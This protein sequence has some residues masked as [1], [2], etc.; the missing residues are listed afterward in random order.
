M[1]RLGDDAFFAQPHG[2]QRLADG[3]VDL[4]RTRE[5]ELLTLE[6]DLSSTAQLRQPLGVVEWCGPADVLRS[7]EI[8]LLHELG[9]DLGGTV[10]LLELTVRL[11]QSLRHI[12][13]AKLSEI[14]RKFS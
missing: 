5:G 7:H 3:I 6:I 13:P 9:I 10:C 12:A 8:D 4:V 14:A 2:K 11:H 1:H